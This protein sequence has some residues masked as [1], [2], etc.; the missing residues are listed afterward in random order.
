ML[1]IYSE[2]GYEDQD[3]LFTHRWD[4]GVPHAIADSVWDLLS[5]AI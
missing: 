5:S 2:A 4:L 3:E 1:K